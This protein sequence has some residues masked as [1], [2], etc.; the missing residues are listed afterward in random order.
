MGEGAES[1]WSEGE[2]GWRRAG[3]ERVTGSSQHGLLGRDVPV[4]WGAAQKMM[5]S[6]WRC[7]S[8][9]KRAATV[10]A[11]TVVEWQPYNEQ[12]HWSA[13]CNLLSPVG[14]CG[15]ADHVSVIACMEVGHHVTDKKAASPTG[16]YTPA[17]YIWSDQNRSYVHPLWSTSCFCSNLW[18]WSRVWMRGRGPIHSKDLVINDGHRLRL[19]KI[20]GS[21]AMRSPSVFAQTLSEKQET[22]VIRQLFWLPGIRMIAAGGMFQHLRNYNP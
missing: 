1:Q 21:S 8:N 12:F 22:W 16:A 11:V 13:T 15:V 19:S 18:I 7:S 14:G 20:S 6:F 9:S 5:S 17:C 2:S 10:P 4:S 3:A